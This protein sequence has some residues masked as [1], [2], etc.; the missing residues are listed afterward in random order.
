MTVAAKQFVR[1]TA[2]GRNRRGRWIDGFRYSGCGGGI[3]TAAGISIAAGISSAAGTCRRCAG[4]AARGNRRCCGCRHR[5]AASA[6]ATA[7]AA[8]AAAA[9]K[10]ARQA[11]H[12]HGDGHVGPH[13]LHPVPSFTNVEVPGIF[14]QQDDGSISVGPG[15]GP[16]SAPWTGLRRCSISQ[17]RQRPSRA[18]AGR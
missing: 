15:A 18:L 14:S 2:H 10:R 4:G 8:T 3:G 1:R 17:H 6:S 13:V 9:R 11:K 12:K 5:F 16:T 7:F